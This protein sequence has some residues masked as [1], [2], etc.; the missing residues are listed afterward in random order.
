MLL[1]SAVSTQTTEVRFAP[2][3][4]SDTVALEWRSVLYGL[5]VDWRFTARPRGRFPDFPLKRSADRSR[6]NKCH[7]KELRFRGKFELAIRSEI[8]IA[9]SDRAQ[10]FTS[11]LQIRN[12][13]EWDVIDECH[14]GVRPRGYRRALPVCAFGSGIAADAGIAVG[15]AF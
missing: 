14:Q 8:I 6:V 9:A 12:D 4:S 7:L 3:E 5:A 11:V 1:L 13:L 2:V 15:S 10:R